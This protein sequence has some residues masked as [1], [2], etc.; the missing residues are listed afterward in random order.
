MTNPPEPPLSAILRPVC[1]IVRTIRM[2]SFK[3]ET[4]NSASAPEALTLLISGPASAKPAE[5]G[6]HNTTSTPSPPPRPL[7]PQA[8]GGRGAERGILEDHRHLGL[9]AHQ[10]RHLQL[11]LGELRCTT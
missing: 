5:Y 9:V 3:Y 6:S 7:F 10:S 4:E 1:L 2:R 11:G 8:V